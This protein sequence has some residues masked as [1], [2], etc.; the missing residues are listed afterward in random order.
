MSKAQTLFSNFTLIVVGPT[1]AKFNPIQPKQSLD[2]YEGDGIELRSK[3]KSWLSECDNLTNISR[4]NPN[5]NHAF[6]AHFN[7]IS[8][9]P[10][11]QRG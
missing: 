4:L 5:I 9:S 11:P 7:L 6:L 8:I 3:S 10:K 1:L 2:Y